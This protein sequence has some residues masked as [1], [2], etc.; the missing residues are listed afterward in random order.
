[1]TPSDSI[2]TRTH[3]MKRSVLE[4]LEGLNED[5]DEGLN[6]ESSLLSATYDLA[7][8]SVGEA[9]ADGLVEL[10]KSAAIQKRQLRPIRRSQS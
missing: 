3:Q 1:M 6:I 10:S 5:C 4:L 9:D 8:L 2:A 7:V